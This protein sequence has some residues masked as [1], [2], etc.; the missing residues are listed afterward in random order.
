MF[1]NSNL[2]TIIIISLLLAASSANAAET[3]AP[4]SNYTA[5]RMVDMEEIRFQIPVEK[6]NNTKEVQEHRNTVAQNIDNDY[7]VYWET[8]M[9]DITE[10]STQ[11]YCLY[12]V[13]C[14][15]G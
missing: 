10:M 7:H 9:V 3:T 14:T 13:N 11:M 8:N 6:F 2:I 12:I 4:P 15:T 1:S 5:G